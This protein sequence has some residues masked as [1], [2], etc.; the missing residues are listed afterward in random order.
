MNQA[1]P[2]TKKFN[3]FGDFGC[4]KLNEATSFPACEKTPMWRGAKKKNQQAK[5]SMGVLGEKKGR[6]ACRLCFE[7]T[8]PPTC[9]NYPVKYM[10]ITCQ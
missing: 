6:G 1:K 9:N 4:F 5:W 10:S 3:N 7:A 8:H 2:N